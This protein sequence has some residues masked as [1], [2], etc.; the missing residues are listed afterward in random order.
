MLMALIVVVLSC[1][2]GMLISW[3]CVKRELL[4]DYEMKLVLLIDS[5][6]SDNDKV[7]TIH[8]LSK[9]NWNICF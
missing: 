8:A 6:C 7:F 4:I 1:L 5:F 9:L 3:L 2:K